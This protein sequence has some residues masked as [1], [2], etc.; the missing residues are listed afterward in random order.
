[1]PGLSTYIPLPG[2][3]WI[4][5]SVYVKYPPPNPHNNILVISKKFSRVEKIVCVSNAGHYTRRY[6]R[7]KDTYL[8]GLEWDDAEL[9]K[10]C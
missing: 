3:T 9:Y 6:F 4:K 8:Q 10:V 5:V 2:Y 1:M 7:P